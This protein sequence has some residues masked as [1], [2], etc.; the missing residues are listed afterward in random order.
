[1]SSRKMP[2]VIVAAAFCACAVV[3]GILLFGQLVIPM[4]SSGATQDATAEGAVSQ[5][6]AT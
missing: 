3:A 5:G 2:S 1:M 4:E 6:T